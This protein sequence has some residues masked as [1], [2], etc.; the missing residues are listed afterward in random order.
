[1]RWGEGA[2]REG[3]FGAIARVRGEPAIRRRSG[4]EA[5][6]RRPGARGPGGGGAGYVCMRLGRGAAEGSDSNWVAEESAS[7]YLDTLFY[8]QDIQQG[9]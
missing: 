1:M 8:T 2:V 9:R 3:K 4:C 7:D 5:G 6:R